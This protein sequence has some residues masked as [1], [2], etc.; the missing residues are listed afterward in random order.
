MASLTLGAGQFC[1]NPGLVLAV[2]GPDLDAFRRPP[3]RRW[4]APRAATMLTPGIH[5][6]YQTGCRPARSEHPRDRRSPGA[7]AAA[8]GPQGQA[9]LFADRCGRASC[10]TRS[11]RRRSSA[12][13]PFVVRCPDV[14]TMRAWSQALEGQLTATIQMDDPATSTR[15]ALLLPVLERKVGRILV[16]G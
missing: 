14:E 8:E 1:T 15:R 10:P 6:A 16:N 9:A 2:E 13:P 4:G 5:T 3:P 11:C 12:P 7:A